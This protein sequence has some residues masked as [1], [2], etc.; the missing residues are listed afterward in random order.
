M[1]SQSRRM[2]KWFEHNLCSL[3][4]NRLGYLASHFGE[5]RNLSILDQE[6][7]SRLLD[8]VKHPPI[9]GRS[10]RPCSKMNSENSNIVGE[11]PASSDLL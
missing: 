11:Y 8:H 4:W 1:H 5:T 2:G 10:M 3:F 6:G 9:R 7:E